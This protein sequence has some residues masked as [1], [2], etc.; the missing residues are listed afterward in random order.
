MS[1]EAFKAAL[2]HDEESISIGGGEPTLHPLFEHFLILAI[3]RVEHVWIATNGKIKEHAL[4]LYR[5]TQKGVIDAELS[6]DQYHE[7]I[8]EEVVDKFLSLS[9]DDRW[10]RGIVKRGIRNTTAFS[11]PFPAGRAYK[12]MGSEGEKVCPCDDIFVHPSGRVTQCGCPRSP[13]IGDVFS[14]Y[15]TVLYGECYRSKAYKQAVKEVREAA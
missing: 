10:D 9:K 7:A 13:T 15:N 12:L 1:L 4:L 3:S 2:S 8:D 11:D 6:R 5:L 14:G